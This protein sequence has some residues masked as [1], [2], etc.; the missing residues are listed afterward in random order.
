MPTNFNIGNALAEQNLPFFDGSQLIWAGAFIILSIIFSIFTWRSQKGF[1][2][3]S[4][5]YWIVNA[6]VFCFGIFFITKAFPRFS[7][8]WVLAG[9]FIVLFAIS[10]MTV[11]SKSKSGDDKKEADKDKK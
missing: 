7:A 10:G 3:R 5:M 9:L 1:N 4:F 2:S 11:A 8:G 6:I